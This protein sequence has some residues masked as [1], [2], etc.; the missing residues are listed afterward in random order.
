VT[1]APP[2]CGHETRQ[3]GCLL[4]ALAAGARPLRAGKAPAV[5]GRTA[6]PPCAHEGDVLS[7]CPAG[8]ESKH[9]RRCLLDASE[10]ETCSR[11]GECARCP[12]HEAATSGVAGATRN[13]AGSGPLKV[14]LPVKS[15]ADSGQKNGLAG[16]AGPLTPGRRHLLYHLLP[17]A[18][19]G[20]WQRNLDQ[21]R[22]RMPLFTGRKVIA[23]C[24]SPRFRD[25]QTG[26]GTFDLDPP[27]AVAEYLGDV[28]GLTILTAPNDPHRREMATWKLLWESVAGFADTDD[29][30]FYAQGKGV[31]RPTNGGVT[32]HEWARVLYSSLLDFWPVVADRLSRFPIAG[33]FKKVGR[34]FGGSRSEWHYSGSFFWAR[35]RD[36]F[37]RQKWRVIDARAWWGNEAWPGLH[38]PA[39]GAGTVFKVGSAAKLDLYKPAY[40]FGQVMPEFRAW[41]GANAGRRTP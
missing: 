21:L 15:Y 24:T 35:I 32:V 12:H 3:D 7:W 6:R 30:V 28:P 23:V 37:D 10:F 22:W 18:G 5:A 41:C 16:P 1:P 14:G 11:A 29:V 8:D 17:V 34:A 25:T 39:A 31:T 36:V 27:D 2:I 9:V 38:W 4:C 40:F 26:R 33:S 20:V 13:V 19:N